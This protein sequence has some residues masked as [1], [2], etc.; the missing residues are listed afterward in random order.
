MEAI[1]DYETSSP[2]VISEDLGRIEYRT[3]PSGALEGI[4]HYDDDVVFFNYADATTHSRHLIIVAVS[5]GSEEQVRVYQRAETGPQLFDLSYVIRGELAGP[6]GEVGATVTDLVEVYPG[7]APP[8][9]EYDLRYGGVDLEYARRNLS[10]EL[11]RVLVDGM[12]SI[13]GVA[14]LPDRA[15]EDF[16]Y[17]E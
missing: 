1:R 9:D 3:P 13:P 5:G 8:R 4:L 2:S 14:G 12:G 10:P 11:F 17:D 16:E 15:L 6:V 7:F